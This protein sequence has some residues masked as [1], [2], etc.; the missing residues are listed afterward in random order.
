MLLQAFKVE[1]LPDK[2]RELY[3]KL[4]FAHRLTHMTRSTSR[5][6]T[7][8]MAQASLLRRVWAHHLPNHMEYQPRA[9]MSRIA[10][11]RDDARETTNVKI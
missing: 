8:L 2:K 3:S 7:D 9:L 5:N 1:R 4:L 11:F 10:F 6:K